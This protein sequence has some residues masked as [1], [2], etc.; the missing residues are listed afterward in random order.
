MLLP[1]DQLLWLL[2]FL[3]LK[4]V[5]AVCVLCLFVGLFPKFF[6]LSKA[7]RII[8][9]CTA[10]LVITV[11]A[12]CVSEVNGKIMWV[13]L[14]SSENDQVAEKAY[15]RLKTDAQI[16]WLIREVNDRQNDDNA[17]FYLARLLGCDLQGSNSQT[18]ILAKLNTDALDPHFFSYNSLNQDIKLIPLPLTPVSVV[19]YYSTKK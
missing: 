18:E 6:G 15:Q 11:G 13:T 8:R 2:F 10:L 12:I 16:E 9:I 4:W 1:D 19:M 7:S 5:I 17:K 14:L 3:R